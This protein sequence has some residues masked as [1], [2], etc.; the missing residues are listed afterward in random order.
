MFKIFY[1]EI[2]YNFSYLAQSN[3]ALAGAFAYEY[4]PK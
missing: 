2:N 4:N 1:L 3:L